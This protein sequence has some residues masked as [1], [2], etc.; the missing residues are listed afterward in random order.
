MG[1]DHY[2]KKSLA[3]LLALLMAFSTV[4]FT[5]TELAFA[6]GSADSAESAGSAGEEILPAAELVVPEL[7]PVPGL[8]DS[9]TLLEGYLEHLAAPEEEAADW[10]VDADDAWTGEEEAAP[11]EEEELVSGEAAPADGKTAK[12]KA[13]RAYLSAVQKKAYDLVLAQLKKIADGQRSSTKI[14]VPLTKLVSKRTFTPSELGVS[15]ITSSNLS[16]C[17]DTARTKLGLN[18]A[19]LSKIIQ[20]LMYDAEYELYWFDKEVGY[21]AY[22]VRNESST[23]YVAYSNRLEFY[24]DADVAFE[25][26]VSK[27]YSASGGKSTYVTSTYKTSAASNA[28][29]TAEQV[30]ESASWRT[31]LNMLETYRDYICGAVSYDSW[32]S[33]QSGIYGDPWQLISVFDNNS[34]TNVVCEGYAKAF[35]LLVDITRKKGY[36]ESD[37]IEARLMTGKFEEKKYD[38]NTGTYSTLNSGPHM[39]NV[40]RMDDN[41]NY[42]VDVTHFDQLNDGGYNAK[43]T[44]WLNGYSSGATT[45]TVY[46]IYQNNGNYAETVYYTY[47]TDE[48]SSENTMGYYT[49]AE[50]QLSTV[51]WSN[52]CGYNSAYEMS[53]ATGKSS[54]HYHNYY[55]WTA[56]GDAVAATCTKAGWSTSYTCNGCG[57]IAQAR[58]KR[59]ALGHDSG[60]WVVARKASYSAVGKKE[61]RCT[62]CGKVLKTATY[63]ISLSAS[64]TKTK[65]NLSYAYTYTGK[66][67][68]PTPK[69]TVVIGGKT[70]TLVNGKD[71]TLSY[72]NNTKIG[73]ATITITG[74]GV[75]TGK[76]TKNFKIMSVTR[77]SGKDR[78]ETAYAIANAVKKKRGVSKFENIIVCDG[79][80]YPDALSASY[81]AKVKKAPILLTQPAKYDATLSYIK[82]NLK[83]GGR[84]YIIGGTGSVPKD[85]QNRLRGYKVTRLGG[86][87][88]YETNLLIL[89]AAGVTNQAMIVC[90]GLQFEDALSASATGRPILLV[91]GTGTGLTTAQKK[92]LRSLRTKTY[93]LVGGTKVITNSIQS[94]IKRYGSTSRI[95]GSD[96]YTR[97]VNIARRFFSGKQSHV[98]VA[99]GRNFPDGLAGSALAVLKG[100]PLILVKDSSSVGSQV[101]AYIKSAKT[102]YVTV[103][104]GP[105]SVSAATL[106][107]TVGVR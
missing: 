84:V 42:L 48:P 18:N 95:S 66:A 99:D 32:S 17:L 69:V 100:G 46:H 78:Y 16:S 62:R 7:T 79:R 82:K 81:L 49:V 80:N 1:G 11:D 26:I 68:K 75:F 101:L 102:F 33:K 93:Y 47:S 13:R 55:S 58:Q 25:F 63:K 89:K 50:R 59:P 35:K 87:D 76:I 15:E 10:A 105:G 73:T 43:A 4:G 104:G 106:Q 71:Y 12:E 107:K 74:K 36:F 54:R 44:R 45:G 9:D 57:E 34:S 96:P 6:A 92:Y 31:D 20:S 91:R 24:S 83:S 51:E 14:R 40:I 3:I 94:D 23:P 53:K 61:L 37:I 27:D 60:K 28:Y 85:F 41:V 70:Y 30:V 2:G 64:S 39:W 103:Y 90:T 65:T 88:R 67:K 21:R 97:S 86:A 22:L 19:N 52:G 77:L 56:N 72:R 29:R 8:P 38:F 5:G 98:S